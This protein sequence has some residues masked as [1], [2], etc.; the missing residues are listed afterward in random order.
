MNVFRRCLVSVVFLVASI[1]CTEAAPR[2]EGGRVPL[3]YLLQIV[4]GRTVTPM[5]GEESML[6]MV[7]RDQAQM[8]ITGVID[9]NER[10]AWCIHL[11]NLPP[12]EVIEEIL[13]GLRALPSAAKDRNSALAISDFL[14]VRFPCKKQPM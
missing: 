5:G 11:S 1:G 4:D 14:K 2:G 13:A 10:G 8:Y 9:T 7:A 3:W 6:K 12:H